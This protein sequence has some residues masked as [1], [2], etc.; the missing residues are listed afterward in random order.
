MELL[1]ESTWLYPMVQGMHI[2][3]FI[4][5]AGA[6][7]LFDLRV[8][9]L[10]STRGEAPVSVRALGL[11]LLPWSVVAALVVVPSGVLMFLV[12]AQALVGNPAF[13]AKVGLLA[14]AAGNAA[15]FHLG[16]GRGWARWESVE[17]SGRAVPAGAKLHA[18][19]SLFLWIS[20][21]GCGRLIAY[22]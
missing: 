20:I 17:P 8:L 15:A 21:V 3:G 18:A 16:V 6:A 4:V 19:A 9:G 1:R 2:L 22:V 11:H 5:L 10:T 7:V 13:V 14:L 12:D